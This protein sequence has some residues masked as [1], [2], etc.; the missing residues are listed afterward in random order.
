M[1]ARR[2]PPAGAVTGA[3]AVAVGSLLLA[4]CGPAALYSR[5]ATAGL[6]TTREAIEAHDWVLDRADSSLTVRDRSPVT[7]TVHVDRVSG[8]AP[9]NS[10]RGDFSLDDLGN[11]DISHLALTKK[12][13]SDRT[14]RAEAEVVTALEDVD[15]ASVDHGDS[16]DDGDD[17]LVLSGDDGLHLEFAVIPGGADD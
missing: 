15:H 9:C 16:D 5:S 10:Y 1:G 6:P 13:C 12:L 3:V 7:L 11:A 17:V 8:L 14:M 2:S 4:G